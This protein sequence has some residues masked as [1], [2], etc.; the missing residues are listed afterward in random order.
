M[1]FLNNL[2]FYKIDLRLIEN[3]II[4]SKTDIKFFLIFY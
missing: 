1:I 4:E 3:E 2:N